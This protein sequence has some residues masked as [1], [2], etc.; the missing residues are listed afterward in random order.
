MH[1][2][3]G[4]AIVPNNILH[5]GRFKGMKKMAS[6]NFSLE[7]IGPLVEEIPDPPLNKVKSQTK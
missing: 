5:I 4:Y 6:A 3:F 1:L 7:F 2:F